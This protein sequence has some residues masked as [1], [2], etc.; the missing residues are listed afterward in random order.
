MMT[1]LTT[2][3]ALKSLVVRLLQVDSHDYALSIFTDEA[4]I[5]QIASN[6]AD[7]DSTNVK[8]RLSFCVIVMLI[9]EWKIRLCDWDLP[10]FLYNY[11]KVVNGFIYF[12]SANDLKD[13]IF[14]LYEDGLAELSKDTNNLLLFVPGKFLKEKRL[15]RIRKSDI[16]RIARSE[17]WEKLPDPQNCK[18]WI[19]LPANYEQLKRS[20]LL[21]KKFSREI[22]AGVDYTGVSVAKKL[23]I[24][25]QQAIKRGTMYI[26]SKPGSSIF[27]RRAES[28]KG[29]KPVGD[30]LL[31]P[32]A[33]SEFDFED[34]P[35]TI[36]QM[37]LPKNS[38]RTQTSQST[39]AT[40]QEIPGKKKA[41]SAQ[42]YIC[43]ED[44]K[45]V[46]PQAIV[47]CEGIDSD[48]K[49]KGKLQNYTLNLGNKRLF[50]GS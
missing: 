21:T 2:D 49:P 40:Q 18:S 37:D 50:P 46:S 27:K 42:V 1:N 28:V 30:S 24:R 45:D 15:Y 23:I 20:Q 43:K 8:V 41:A 29:D 13:Q 22:L 35:T 38:K 34:S 33:L 39:K 7:K 25:N 36:K 31:T 26:D 44:S 3:E 12:S 19:K 11:F 48:S 6:L 5:Y 16:D 10:Q 4:S 47:C 14:K 9:A 32:I 17:S